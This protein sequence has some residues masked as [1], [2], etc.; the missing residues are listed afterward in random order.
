MQDTLQI[1]DTDHSSAKEARMLRKKVVNKKRQ[2]DATGDPSLSHF[3]VSYFQYLH[4]HFTL[5]P[6]SIPSQTE[7]VFSTFQ[8]KFHVGDYLFLLE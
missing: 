1:K 2:R 6:D 5:C 7:P 4:L 8:G 3:P